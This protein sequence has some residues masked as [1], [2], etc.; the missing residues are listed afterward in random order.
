MVKECKWFN[1]VQ[2]SCQEWQNFIYF[3]FLISYDYLFPCEDGSIV[4]EF[5]S[6]PGVAL[7]LPLGGE[8]QA[9]LLARKV[10]WFLNAFLLKEQ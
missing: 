10:V 9:T 2:D 1:L 6:E 4:F 8:A 3:F 5:L 7:L